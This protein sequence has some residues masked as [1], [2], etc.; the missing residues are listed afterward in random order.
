MSSFLI[1][2]WPPNVRALRIDDVSIDLRLRR[3][4]RTDGAADVP[5]RP[6]NLLRIFLA[7]PN[8]LHTRAELFRRVWKGVVVED[9]NLSQSVWH[10]RR[11]L[12]EGGR[13][14]I[15]TVAK[16]GYVFEP[17]AAIVPVIEESGLMDVPAPAVLIG[18]DDP[19]V[20]DT[21]P[22]D[23]VESLRAALSPATDLAD[24]ADIP[25]MPQAGGRAPP[26]R[27]ARRLP[28]LTGIAALIGLVALFL[29]P[30]VP[31]S[32][33]REPEAIRVVLIDADAGPG[34]PVEPTQWPK[35]LLRAWL[36]WKLSYARNVRVLSPSQLA[37]GD[38]DGG[39][40]RIVLLSMPAG[41]G[42]QFS[43][44]AHI[45]GGGTV[46]DLAVT[47]DIDQMPDLVD[48]LSDRIIAAL[49]PATVPVRWLPVDHEPS[50]VRAPVTQLALEESPHAPVLSGAKLT[51]GH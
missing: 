46:R 18:A 37:R 2:P 39:H 51:T 4:E 19:A 38:G 27:L 7:E 42:R 43:L 5:Q 13:K 35:A 40:E 30:A 33:S 29:I 48:E 1:S 49:A 11:A 25:D 15:R 9:A 45:G 20:A 3:V 14:W 12:G 22:V 41:D 34:S 17:P 50:R 32:W 23:G 8:V 10:L 44:H 21:G 31:A 36:Q 6:F 26:E 16:S 47:G 28:W 24:T